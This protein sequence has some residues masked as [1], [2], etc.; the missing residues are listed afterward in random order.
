MDE[1]L[2][3]HAMAELLAINAHQN[4]NLAKINFLYRQQYKDV[5]A[6]KLFGRDFS[7][8]RAANARIIAKNKG[9]K[10]APGKP[11]NFSRL[12]EHFKKRA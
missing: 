3:I 1:P 11:R 2:Q 10:V 7:K 4:P 6:K 9:T 5:L 8:L 12:R